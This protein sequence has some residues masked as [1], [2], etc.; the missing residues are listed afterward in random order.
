MN[1][2]I[3]KNA[4]I[5]KGGRMKI[6]GSILILLNFSYLNACPICFTQSGELIRRGIFNSGFWL[7][8]FY[9]T[10][11]FLCFFLIILLCYRGKLS[12][13]GVTEDEKQ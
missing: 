2:G 3:L 9:S 12:F 7:Y 11:P 5:F 10:L 6:I 13:L 1:Y 4:L 8:L